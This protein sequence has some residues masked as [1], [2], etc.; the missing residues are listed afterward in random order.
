MAD[1]ASRGAH[2]YQSVLKEILKL[3]Y[4]EILQIFSWSDYEAP[5][6]RECCLERIVKA[7][8]PEKTI[9]YYEKW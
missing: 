9:E 3:Q 6:N 2:K 1:K 5:L 7:Y 4:W 8:N